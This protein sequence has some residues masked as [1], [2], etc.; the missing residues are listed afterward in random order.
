MKELEKIGLEIQS[1]TLY[2]IREIGYFEKKKGQEIDASVVV[3]GF[4]GCSSFD[5]GCA[6]IIDNLNPGLN[7]KIK[8]FAG[9]IA[10][11]MLTLRH[12]LTIVTGD[13]TQKLQELKK[14][15]SGN[16]TELEG[17]PR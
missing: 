15:F 12:D 9:E 7:W 8:D 5:D 3:N 14:Q 2:P 1:E 16:I 17:N 10:L 11:P 4:H 6:R 13:K